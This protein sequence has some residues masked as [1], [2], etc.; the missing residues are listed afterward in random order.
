[1][2]RLQQALAGQTDSYILP[3]LW[4]RG[5]SSAEIAQQLD[6]IEACGIREICLESRPHPDFCG[7]RW[8]QALDFLL[9]EARRRGLRVWILDDDKFPTGHANGAFE[10][11]CPEK[12]K[13]YLAE[14]HM[15]ILGPC[16]ENAV[17]IEN[18][19]QPDGQL[20]GVVALPKPDS[21]T[22]AVQRAGA[23]DL[24]SRV[25]GGFVYFDLPRGAYRLFVFYRTQ[26][27]G[28]RE[29]YMNLIDRA[30][31]QVLLEEVYEPHYAHYALYF[32][33][34]LAGFFSDE[35]ELGNVKGY[36][37]HVALGTPD[38]RLPWSG[39]LEQAL[40]SDF[41]AGFLP[42]LAALWYEC[43]EGT[44]AVRSQYM[45]RLGELVESCFSRPLGDWC[46]AHGVEH[47]GHVIEDD[48]AHARLGCGPGDYFRV[49]A[50]QAMAGVDVVHHQIVPGFTGKIHQ[51]IAGDADGEFFQ[52]GLAKLASSCAHIDPEKQ[53]RA[54][55]EI[56]GNY[57]WAEGV[58]LMK[59]LTDH[60]LV[61]GINHF[62]P[63]AFSMRFPDPDCPPHF[64]AA[65]SN[66]E[67]GCFAAL[68]RYMQRACHLLSGGVPCMD[69]AVLYHAQAEWA[70]EAQPYQKAVRAL[71]ENQL[72]CD[73][74]P[75]EAL[76]RAQVENGR[77]CLG[78]G[79]YGVL[80]L[81]QCRRLPR[82]AAAFAAAH[83]A[84][85]LKTLVAGALPESDTCGRALPPAFFAAAEAVP[86]EKLAARCRALAPAQLCAVP[87]PACLRS[88]L[89]RQADGWVL[90]LMN[91]STEE[92]VDARIS[93]PQ[94]AGAVLTRAE[95][96]SGRAWREPFAQGAFSLHLA[97]G[98]A[99]FYVL[100]AEPDAAS[101]A[102]APD[103]PRGA[104][105]ETRVLDGG[106]RLSRRRAGSAET[107]FCRELAA[108]E[109]PNQ[110]GPA[111]DVHFSGTYRYETALTLAGTG[112]RTLLRIPCAG[113]AAQIIVNGR[114]CGWLAQF[115]G[116]VEV[117]HA[118]RAGENQI[119]IE[120]ATTLVW[121]LRDGASTHLQ[122]GRTGLLAAP[123]WIVYRD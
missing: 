98:E 17:L 86:L 63:H 41:G 4:M 25:R 121:Q 89:V 74:I 8:W 106:W 24:T 118:L 101:D 56:F 71:A 20:L 105:A 26:K 58:G 76:A 88:C 53:G 91:E 11:R 69:A 12:A 39:A 117:T 109:Y 66:P 31:V 19:L 54:L 75:P 79:R 2:K 92:T 84:E 33:S 37:F 110:N 9:P 65:G 107:E 64:Y 97:P 36:S 94:C 115:P 59:W 77:L 72:D 82:A 34:T 62:T 108:G 120:T 104:R 83:A 102:P 28:G 100:Q 55:C 113:D 96:W 67:F 10:T 3:F 68:M 87:S 22:R 13:W 90:M 70:G 73:V 30:S 29:H 38:I 40:R 80:V 112:G 27:N 7:T 51:W 57:G 32:G 18:F 46:R 23:I 1:M 111:G 21:E 103:A 42:D 119:V 15:D 123:E 6:A 48:N 49:M 50:G 52:F 5:E 16:T 85:G 45:G 44:P 47:I 43:G 95:L 14:R 99:A 61:R 116:S 114:S 81:P 93:L 60:M 35:P 122:L 78:G